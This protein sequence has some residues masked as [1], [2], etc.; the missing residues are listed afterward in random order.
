MGERR[1]AREA[2]VQMLYQWDINRQPVERLLKAFWE[3]G[4][5]PEPVRY[6]ARRLVEGTLAQVDRIDALIS[7]QAER[8]RLPRM[9]TVDRNVL[10]VAIYELLFEDTPKKVVINEA[11]EVTKKFSSPQAV[12]FVN[13]VLDGVRLKM[14]TPEGAR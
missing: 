5:Q 1:K 14:E 11:L 12:Q 6:F 4:E 9:A 2:A 10:R 7:E 13:G 8:W 3:L